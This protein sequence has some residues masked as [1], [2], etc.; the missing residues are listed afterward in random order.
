M[1]KSKDWGGKRVGAGRPVG[2][3]GSYKAPEE[4]KDGRIVVVCKVEEMN[5]IKEFA[6]ASGKTVS[7][8]IVDEILK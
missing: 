8:F 7:R 1:E 2:S 3:T 5:K 4:K 6:Q